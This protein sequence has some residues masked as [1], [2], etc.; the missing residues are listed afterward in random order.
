MWQ[1]RTGNRPPYADFRREIILCAWH[2]PS[3]C[4]GDNCWR[5]DGAGSVEEEATDGYGLALRE[6]A[7]TKGREVFEYGERRSPLRNRENK[8]LRNRTHKERWE[9]IQGKRGLGR[10]GRRTK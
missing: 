1:G 9:W 2:F 8:N 10:L 6:A 3:D 4:G 7:D 5:A